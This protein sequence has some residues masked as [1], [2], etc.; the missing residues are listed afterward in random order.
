MAMNG[1]GSPATSR[2]TSGSGSCLAQ[3]MSKRAQAESIMNDR[4]DLHTCALRWH[5]SSSLRNPSKSTAYIRCLQ[6][7]NMHQL[8]RSIHGCQCV[9]PWLSVRVGSQETVCKGCSCFICRC[10]GACDYFVAYTCP[11]R[12]LR[13]FRSPAACGYRAVLVPVYQVFI[14]FTWYEQR[15]LYS[16]CPHVLPPFTPL[17]W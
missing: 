13:G 14:S 6:P 16:S 1:P 7:D 17:L 15:M 3:M 2:L 9:V 11:R 5:T 8:E 12:S 4:L 10:R